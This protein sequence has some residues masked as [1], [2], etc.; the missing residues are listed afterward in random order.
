[1]LRILEEVCVASQMKTSL[2]T[3]SS[4]THCGGCVVCPS[5]VEQC[6]AAIRR[7]HAKNERDPPLHSSRRNPLRETLFFLRAAWD[8]EFV[9][10]SWV[11][12]DISLRNKNARCHDF[13]FFSV[14]G[15]VC[16]RL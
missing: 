8:R 12:C 6:A 2:S 16:A 7:G 9:F 11:A 1:M 14:A 4:V 5:D 15:V 10:V 3:H 13:V